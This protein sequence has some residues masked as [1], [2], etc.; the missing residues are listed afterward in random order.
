MIAASCAWAP[1][2]CMS[3]T[4]MHLLLMVQEVWLLSNTR[5]PFMVRGSQTL[6]A[7]ST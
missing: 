5:N 6:M 1:Q 7:V 4:S 3:R 2:R